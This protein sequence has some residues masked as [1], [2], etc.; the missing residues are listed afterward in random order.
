MTVGQLVNNAF[1]VLGTLITI[2]VATKGILLL[3]LV[4]IIA[5]YAWL[6]GFFR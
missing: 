6:Q 2:A 5:I 3:P 1:A 4:P